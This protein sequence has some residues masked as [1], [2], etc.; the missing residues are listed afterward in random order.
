MKRVLSFMCVF[1]LLIG[2]LFTMSS[3]KRT[4]NN[5]AGSVYYLNFKPEQD[6]EW[7]ALAKAYT[8]ET[9]VKVTVVNNLS[10]FAPITEADSY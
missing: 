3:C 6:D 4:Q 8:D 10:G 7:K 2:G 1:A 9:G 5:G